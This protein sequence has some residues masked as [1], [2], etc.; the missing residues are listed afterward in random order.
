MLRILACLPFDLAFDV[1]VQI[2]IKDAFSKP[3]LQ[4]TSSSTGIGSK[5]KGVKGLN[6][7]TTSKGVK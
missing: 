7:Y 1:L 5:L 2:L 3:S 6:P 4:K